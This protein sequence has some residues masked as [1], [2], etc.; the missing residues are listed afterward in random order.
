MALE[1]QVRVVQAAY[2]AFARGDFDQLLELFSERAIWDATDALWTKG[3][4]FGHDGIRDYFARLGRLW[5]GLRLDDYDIEPVRPG[6]VLVRGRL[7][8]RDGA[9]GEIADAPF[10]HWVEVDA[11]GKIARLRILVDPDR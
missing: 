10:V 2:A 1:S 9:T 5:E 3:M 8:G 11:E 4:F 7:R 6:M